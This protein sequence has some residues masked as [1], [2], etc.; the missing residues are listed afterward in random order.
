M[1]VPNVPGVPKEARADPNNR[2]DHGQQ[3][4]EFG[5]DPIE[6][7]QHAADD[8]RE[9]LSEASSSD[10]FRVEMRQSAGK[11]WPRKDAENAK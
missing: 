6:A 11:I 2:R 5:D 7:A 8:N 1:V 4:R 10:Q 3:D 9:L